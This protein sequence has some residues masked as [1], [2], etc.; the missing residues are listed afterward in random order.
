[1]AK[2][3][4]IIFD[5]DGVLI[6]SEVLSCRCLSE[7]LA[8]YG[9]TLGVDQAQDLFLG[10]S[11]TAVREHYDALGHS[12]PEQ[13][14]DELRASIRAAFHSSLCPIEGVNSVLEDLLIPHCV[15]SS[16]DVDRVSF[17][18]S[19]TGLARHF[20]TR[21]YTSQ[22][23]ERGKPAPDLFLYAAERMK[24]APHRTLV[25][26]DSIS[27]VKAGKAAGM[28]VWG[29]VGGSHYQS[30]DGKAILREAGADRVFGRMADF[31][32]T[33]RQGD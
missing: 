23:V 32:R 31:W 8:R 18:L 20:D 21:L 25:I 24:V 22:M 14:P 30:R 9:I 7:V 33:D 11:V 28:I 27:G 10:R 19:L 13:F 1:M 15:A 12:I 17:S 16:S 3:D 2:P 4:L 5:C 29:F 26:E 6:D